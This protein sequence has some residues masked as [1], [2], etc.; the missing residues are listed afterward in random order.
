MDRSPDS[1][2][3]P[4]RTMAEHAAGALKAAGILV[5]KRA[6][7]TTLTTV[8]LPRAYRD[9][10]RAVHLNATRRPEF[11]QLFESVDAVC[12]ERQRVAARATTRSAGETLV[13]RAK[14]A[15]ADAADLAR[16][17]ALDVQ[18]F[19]AYAK[20]GEAV[21]E[22]HGVAA[23]SA[24]L[25]EP[26]ASALARRDR[27]DQDLAEIEGASPGT[28]VTP[29]RT[30]WGVGLCAGVAVM[31][32]WMGVGARRGDRSGGDATPRTTN[33]AASI[34]TKQ[35]NAVQRGMLK[36]AVEDMLGPPAERT[37]ETQE[38][39]VYGSRGETFGSEFVNTIVF[40]YKL[41]GKAGK[42]AIFVF[43]GR[44]TNPPLTEKAVIGP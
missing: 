29:T 25:V 1:A 24:A 30:L 38:R 8:T 10:G 22:R 34:T 7:R 11:P 3:S 4:T 19:Q 14:K 16:T 15:A 20:L 26:I 42:S 37:I 9:L 39:H 41:A 40:T 18:L 44:G 6:E 35:F 21:H 31:A 32:L 2:Q 12:A 33:A 36:F 17:K 43:E 5:A 28:W 27:L 13:D 23:G